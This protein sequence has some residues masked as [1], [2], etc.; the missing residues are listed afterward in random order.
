LGR[1]EPHYRR[2]AVFKLRIFIHVA[3]TTTFQASLRDDRTECVPP[4][5][6]L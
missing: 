6:P 3:T 4:F 2:K 5:P 1:C